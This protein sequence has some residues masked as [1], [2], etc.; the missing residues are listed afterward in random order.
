[1]TEPTDDSATGPTTTRVTGP[2]T[3]DTV[4]AAM[5]ALTAGPP[6]MPPDA[7]TSEPFALPVPGRWA[8]AS[9]RTPREAGVVLYVHGGGFEQSNPEFEH[10]MAYR[11][12]KAAGR[13]AF[14]IDY[15]LAPEHPFPAAHD[16]VVAVY[17]AL[18]AEGVP[19]GRTVLFG[20][21]AGATLVLGALL[22]VRAAGV[23]LPGAA[24]PVSPI[25]D[26]TLASPSIDA[27]AGP[28][29]IGRD[30]LEHIVGR[31]LGGRPNDR[32]PQSP[33]HGDPAGLPRLLLVAGGNE[34][35]LDD[36]R[37]FAEAAA[38]A[39]VE[40]ALDVY[41]GMPHAFH[42]AALLEPRPPVGAAFLERLS[43]WLDR[44]DQNTPA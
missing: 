7:D 40:V 22:A 18:L 38:G 14:A 12:S 25:A 17:R 37:R 42:L 43:S 11:L 41:D 8:N 16:E 13:P 6:P 30:V 39:G 5:G 31:Y 27:P 36:A 33:L 34:V 23:P 21:S 35:L 44:S 29:M 2:D 32:A 3:F 24:V 19:P 1:M 15:S 28:D 9:G 10:P 26:L 20:E 4:V